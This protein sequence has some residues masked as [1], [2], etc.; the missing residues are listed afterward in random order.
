M[1][2]ET[3]Q[4]L[5]LSSFADDDQFEELAPAEANA[6]KKE[7]VILSLF[8]ID[9]EKRKLS[10]SL[11]EEMWNQLGLKEFVRVG[12]LASAGILKIIPDEQGPFKLLKFRKGGRR[13]VRIPLSPDIRPKL[14]CKYLPPWQLVEGKLIIKV[15]EQ[16]YEAPEPQAIEEQKTKMVQYQPRSTSGSSIAQSKE[17]SV[18]LPSSAKDLTPQLLGDP[19]PGRS[20]LDQQRRR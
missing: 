12:Y 15:P 10:I 2:G 1:N 8:C 13:C 16:F 7:P 3:N 18:T 14:Y 6:L 11:G 4:E 19:A 5:D 9:P 17:K 20:A